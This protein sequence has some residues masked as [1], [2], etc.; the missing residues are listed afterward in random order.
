MFEGLILYIVLI[1]TK[2][3]T[4]LIIIIIL[5]AIRLQIND[6]LNEYACD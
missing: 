3:I 5:F 1:N 6:T 4:W 2:K